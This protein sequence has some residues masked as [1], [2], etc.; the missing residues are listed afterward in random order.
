MHVTV[1]V[2]N[3][4]RRKTREN[5]IVDIL[6]QGENLLG[7]RYALVLAI[8]ISAIQYIYVDVYMCV[9]AS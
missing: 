9:Y 1:D 6:W 8:S 5:E 2:K 3:Q 7:L 4:R